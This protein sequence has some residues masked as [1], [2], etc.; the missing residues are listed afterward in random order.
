MGWVGLVL[1]KSTARVI[2]SVDGNKRQLSF[3][4]TPKVI[5]FPSS[6]I[7]LSLL[8]LSELSL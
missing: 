3:E 4:E 8:T 1:G 7:F 6:T 5:R 2:Q